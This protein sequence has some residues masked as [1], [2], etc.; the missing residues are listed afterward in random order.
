MFT[1]IS[2]LKVR[3]AETDQMGV[4]HHGNYAIYLELARLEWLE[5]IGFSYKKLEGEGVMLPVYDLKFS[6]KQPAYFDDILT[7]ETSLAKMPSAS[8][9]FDY[10]IY[11]TDHE[12]IT[13]AQ[14]TLVFVDVKTRR[15][16]RCPKAILERLNEE[17]IKH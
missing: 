17:S 11:N 12:L 2:T 4:V 10:K 14:S 6:F 9:V 5:N 15:P 8:I 16:I 1:Y 7:V 3:Y 13:S